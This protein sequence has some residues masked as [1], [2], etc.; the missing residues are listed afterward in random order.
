MVTRAEGEALT[1]TKKI[2]RWQSGGLAL[3]LLAALSL[4]GCGRAKEAKSKGAMA[5]ADASSRKGP[6]PPK[7]SGQVSIDAAAHMLSRV[8]D[9]NRKFTA[10]H[11]SEHFTPF[12]NEQHPR[13]TVVAC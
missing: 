10:S 12:L 1:M 8:L 13:A 9:D 7:P 2:R 6:K 3:S 5:V 4:V 11:P